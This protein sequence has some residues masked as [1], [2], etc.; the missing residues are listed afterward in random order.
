MIIQNKPKKK[1]Y[2]EESFS[3]FDYKNLGKVRTAIDENYSTW[4]CLKDVC[5]ILGI[6]NSRALNKRIPGDFMSS[7]CIEMITATKLD[8]TPAMQKIPMT[9]V[10]EAGLYLTI[11]R[12]RKLKAREFMV[13]VLSEILPTLSKVILQHRKKN[14]MQRQ[15]LKYN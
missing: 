15:I 7:I 4:F 2:I 12:S 9:F 1:G 13:W 11:G 6:V 10:N 14:E 3:A 8:G 5:D